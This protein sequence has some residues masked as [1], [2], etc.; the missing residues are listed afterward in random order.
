MK[1]LQILYQI[2][3]QLITSYKLGM[4]I[5]TIDFG[6]RAAVIYYILNDGSYFIGLCPTDNFERY[7]LPLETI[8][9]NLKDI[10]NN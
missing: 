10:I 2:I 9:D 3:K 4:K 8:Q 5:S 1:K 6:T 7:D